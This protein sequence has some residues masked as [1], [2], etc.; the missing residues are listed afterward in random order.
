MSFLT[1]LEYFVCDE[2][3]SFLSF[4]ITIFQFAMYGQMND[5]AVELKEFGMTKYCFQVLILLKMCIIYSKMIMTPRQNGKP[6]FLS[7]TFNIEKRLF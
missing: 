5:F 7:S 4:P 2:F 6:A 3:H 1:D